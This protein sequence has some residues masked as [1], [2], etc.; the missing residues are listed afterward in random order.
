MAGQAFGYQ[1]AAP[2]GFLPGTL[3]SVDYGASGTWSTNPNGYV[4]GSFG[5]L[6]P[7]SADQNIGTW[8]TLDAG[9]SYVS[10]G[11]W[12]RYF[13]HLDGGSAGGYD[14]LLFVNGDRTPATGI[15]A[16]GTATYAAH[17][18]F[19]LSSNLAAGIPFTLSADF[20]QRTISTEIDQ[21]YRYNP[22]GDLLDYPAPGIH[23]GGSAPFSNS[24]T[25]DIPLS[26]TVNYNA[27]YA[28]NVPQAP[29]GQPV[30]GTMNGAFF[31]PHAEQVGGTFAIGA[32][33]GAALLQDAFV[34]Q[35]KP[36]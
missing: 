30:T 35:Q 22:N 6:L 29:P 26:G 27:G 17:T 11:E 19:L 16:S 8:L 18:L 28:I 13:V 10:M 3:T 12:E 15:P 33:G 32:T 36:Q 23:V 4:V 5:K 34:G 2:A 14:H 31:G 1:L 25:F 20:G 21:N 7:F 9:Y 24:G